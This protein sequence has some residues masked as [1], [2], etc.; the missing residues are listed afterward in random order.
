MACSG[1]DQ[2]KDLVGDLGGERDQGGGADH[3]LGGDDR[4]DHAL[5][6]GVGAGH[7][8]AE[9]VTC[10]GDGVRLEHFGDGGEPFG[11]RIVAAGLADL[12]GDERGHL[13][14][15]RGRVNVGSVPGDH[16]AVLQ[17]L[18]P[19]LNGAAGDPEAPGGLQYAH[20]GLGGEQFDKRGVEVVDHSVVTNSHEKAT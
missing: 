15:Q 16:A 20:P 11:H 17:P 9:H 8:P 13:I 10:P 19:C 5:Q 18:Q 6:V 2:G 7:H 3:A 1:A 14:A 12:E 4:V